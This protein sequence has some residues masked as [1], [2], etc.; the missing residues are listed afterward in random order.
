MK[1]MIRK[2]GKELFYKGRYSQNKRRRQSYAKVSILLA[3]A[4]LGRVSQQ[5]LLKEKRKSN[6]GIKGEQIEQSNQD[7]FHERH[8]N[9]KKFLSKI[10]TERKLQEKYK[11]DSNSRSDIG[12]KSDFK[13]PGSGLT[14]HYNSLV[15]QNR[16]FY[17]N[18]MS[19][20]YPEKIMELI[21]AMGFNFKIMEAYN[22]TMSSGSKSGEDYSLN[23]E[24]RE[25]QGEVLLI[26]DFNDQ[27]VLEKSQIEVR[28]ILID[29]F[30]LIK[31][32]TELIARNQSGKEISHS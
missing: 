25:A 14:S 1:I 3:L 11:A 13:S 23:T 8:L 22:I 27:V 30:Y 29:P 7:Q 28:L 12:F 2:Q 4:V 17:N 31:G 5:R 32:Y 21:K 20:R 15:P 9:F 18:T 16:T 10:C 19:L 24:I 26:F 6:S